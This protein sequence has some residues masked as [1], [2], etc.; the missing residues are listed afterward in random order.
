M[1]PGQRARLACLRAAP[2][3]CVAPGMLRI[4]TLVLPTCIATLLRCLA[5]CP[6]LLAFSMHACFSC[7]DQA[8]PQIALN[9]CCLLRCSERPGGAPPV[10][11]PTAPRPAGQQ[12]QQ[13]AGG[14][15]HAAPVHRHARRRRAARGAA[16]AGAQ[17][18]LRRRREPIAPLAL[19]Q[20]RHLRMVG[21]CQGCLGFS[22]ANSTGGAGTYMC[23]PCRPPAP[24]K[25]LLFAG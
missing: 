20:R 10:C 16:A 25:R 18:G 11:D 9:N 6:P 17:G 13:P 21:T 7:P 2:N 14:V 3:H 5:C 23:W 1:Q 22:A 15:R 12:L 24:S 4:V 8:M 19:R